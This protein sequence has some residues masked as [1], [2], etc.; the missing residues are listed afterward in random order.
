MKFKFFFVI[1]TFFRK[2]RAASEDNLN[3]KKAA[4]KASKRLEDKGKVAVKGKVAGSVKKKAE[5][6]TEADKENTEQPKLNPVCSSIPIPSLKKK[7]AVV[8][9]EPIS[10]TSDV[11]TRAGGESPPR[12]TLLQKAK[13]KRS[14]PQKN[15]FGSFH[16]DHESTTD[17]VLTEFIRHPRWERC[18]IHMRVLVFILINLVYAN[19]N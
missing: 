18:V 10:G 1:T 16:S 14:G 15:I 8:F 4:E 6:V 12:L 11:G 19:A 17:A 5:I 3:R 9:Q 2:L 13:S 7:K